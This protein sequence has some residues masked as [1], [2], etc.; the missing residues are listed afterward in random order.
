[1][2][3]IQELDIV[4]ALLHPTL[5]NPCLY[6]SAHAVIKYESVEDILTSFPQ[7]GELGFCLCQ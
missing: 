2:L 3:A 1:M 4:Q 6:S 5:R 7:E